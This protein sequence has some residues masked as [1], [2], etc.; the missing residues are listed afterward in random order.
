M[1]ILIVVLIVVIVVLVI[2][3]I[4]SV[5]TNR[6]A[7]VRRGELK[8]A[9]NARHAAEQNLTA[10]EIAVDKI[11]SETDKFSDIDSVLAASVR[12][13]IREYRQGRIN[14]TA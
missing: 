6:G 10:L 9:N 2:M 14:Q 4:A 3:L 12:Q 8:R 5:L 1:K 7:N 11:E 13:C